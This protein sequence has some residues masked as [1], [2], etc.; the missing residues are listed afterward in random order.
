LILPSGGCSYSNCPLDG[1][2]CG[3]ETQPRTYGTS[4]TPTSNGIQCKAHYNCPNNPT[5]YTFSYNCGSTCTSVTGSVSGSQSLANNTTVTLSNYCTAPSGQT[6]E[7]TCGNRASLSSNTFTLTASTSCTATCSAQTPTCSSYNSN[8]TACG[9]T[10]GCRYCVPTST[11]LTTTNYASQCLSTPPTCSSLT[12]Q[13]QNKCNSTDGCEWCVDKCVDSNTCNTE[14]GVGPK[15][16]ETS[17][18]GM[19]AQTGFNG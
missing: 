9:N 1:W 16:Q 18:D 7:W 6:I 3:N 15:W 5:V 12:S 19:T 17:A 11:C 2:T 8:P 10:S 4:Y 14:E 13:G